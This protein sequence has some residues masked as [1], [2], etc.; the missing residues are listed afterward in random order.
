VRDLRVVGVHGVL[1]EERERAQP[2]SVDLDV[3]IDTAAAGASD[4][5]ADT[6]DYADLVERVARVVESQ[7]F[8]LLEALAT[9]ACDS[10][11]RADTRVAACALTVRKLRPP[12]ARD[13]G[14][15][16]VRV[17]RRRDPDAPATAG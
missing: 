15:V 16:G 4:A 9:A 7:S 12:L 10:V 6:V 8:A 13:V 2:F 3:F 11:L 1:A 17:L 14:S 5:L